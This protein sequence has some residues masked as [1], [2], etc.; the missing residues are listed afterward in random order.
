MRLEGQS[1]RS[2]GHPTDPRWKGP[3]AHGVFARRCLGAAVLV[4]LLS[5]G[6]GTE[7]GEATTCEAAGDLLRTMARGFTEDVPEAEVSSAVDRLVTEAE[8]SGDPELRENAQ[9]LGAA[10][11]RSGGGGD[12]AP[13]EA[14]GRA[15]EEV[16][17]TCVERGFGFPDMGFD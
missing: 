16:A 14:F 17:S 2:L 7:S 13:D 11:E 9:R 3:W 1:T 5:C 8:S 15:A 10:W 12:A 4:I 6:Q